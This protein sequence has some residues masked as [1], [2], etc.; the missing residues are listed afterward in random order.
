MARY[1]WIRIFIFSAIVLYGLYA[2]TVSPGPVNANVTLTKTA[3]P[4]TFTKVGEIITY[5]YILEPESQRLD[6]NFSSISDFPL[7]SEFDCDHP[8][9][10]EPIKPSKADIYTEKTTDKRITCTATYIITQEDVNKGFVTSKASA[11]V[12]FAGRMSYVGC[13]VCG[14]LPP[15]PTGVVDEVAAFTVNAAEITVKYEPPTEALI[16]PAEPVVPEPVVPEPVAPEP[17]VPEPVAPEP[18]LSG[19]V[20]YCDFTTAAINF[21][22]ARD[23][24]EVDA[25]LKD[26]SLIIKVNDTTAS[27]LV[28]PNTTVVSCSVPKR[29]MS[30]P[31]KVETLLN[32]VSVDNFSND[33]FECITSVAGG[34]SKWSKCSVACGGGYQTRTCTNPAPIAPGANCVG[35]D[36]QVCNP[37]PCPLPPPP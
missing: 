24:A 17:V 6:M 23:L 28:P 16:V 26:G 15:I 30:K 2:C 33:G 20:P 37:D 12:L 1:R 19:V 4:A 21:R 8:R 36:S 34:W 27:C 14:C 5:T 25:A 9:I 18:V 29:P 35:S 13:Y 31:I 3:N 22:A 7:S 11:T 32:D 10:G